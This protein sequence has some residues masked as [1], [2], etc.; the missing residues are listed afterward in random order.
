MRVLLY[1]ELFFEDGSDSAV[2][3]DSDSDSDVEDGSDSGFLA[4]RVKISGAKR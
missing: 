4:S 1:P 3:S 2:D